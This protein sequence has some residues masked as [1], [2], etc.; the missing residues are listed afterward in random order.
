MTNLENEKLVRYLVALDRPGR[1]FRAEDDTRWGG[2]LEPAPEEVP[3]GHGGGLRVAL[4]GS[5]VFGYLVL[6]TLA[7]YQLRYPGKLSLVGLVTDDP[8]NPDAKISLKKRIWHLLDLPYRVVNETTILESALSNGIPAY[9]GEVKVESF[10]RLLAAW[11]PDAILVCVFGQ[12]ID[13][14]IIEL[15]P[16]GIYNFHPSDLASG[17]GAGP[18]PYDDLAARDAPTG[19][20]TVHHVTEEVDGGAIVGQSPPVNV[21]D[22]AGRLPASPQVVYEKL[23]E[24]LGPLAFL[25]VEELC[26]RREEGRTGR[27]D[28][29]DLE[30]SMPNVLKARFLRPIQGDA[31]PGVLLPSLTKEL[32]G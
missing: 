28:R 2:L 29:L 18:A 8:L 10:R 12:V 13:A 15:P 27:I 24:A 26:R 31:T 7:R 16:M 21:R 25:L 30:E 4:F 11:R 20:W 23:A 3:A 19:K 17:V 22:A 6:D 32:F 9:T 1:R 14:R 5:W